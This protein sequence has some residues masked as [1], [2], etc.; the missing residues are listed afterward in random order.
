MISR[1]R[2]SF[3]T[4]I[5]GTPGL[6]VCST[7]RF[8]SPLP[9]VNVQ[10]HEVGLVSLRRTPPRSDRTFY[11]FA[12][13]TATFVRRVLGPW[14]G[15]EKLPRVRG[16]RRGRK[17]GKKETK[18]LLPDGHHG[19]ERQGGPRRSNGDISLTQVRIAKDPRATVKGV[20]PSPCR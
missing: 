2:D 18:K 17:E 11:L 19:S 15:T 6:K 7:F 4:R 9:P 1:L 3:S 5:I 16:R 8:S 13:S 10:K 14:S 12:N 20:L